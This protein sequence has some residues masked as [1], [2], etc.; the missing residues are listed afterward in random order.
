MLTFRNPAWEWDTYPLVVR[1]PLFQ[2]KSLA[3]YKY[4]VV[5][6][7]EQPVRGA[8]GQSNS[9]GSG[10]QTRCYYDGNG[11][12]RPKVAECRPCREWRRRAATSQ[13]CSVG[14]I[15][16]YV[17]EVIHRIKNGNPGSATL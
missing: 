12:L 1:T 14:Y 17:I 7:S 16:L 8:G 6:A 10:R 9:T 13:S 15:L 3:F 11:Q 5:A 2:T 4:T